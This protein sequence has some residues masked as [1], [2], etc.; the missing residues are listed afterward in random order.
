[1]KSMQWDDVRHFLALSRE[2]S[3]SATARVLRVDHST[4][5]RRVTSLETALQTKLFDRMARGWLLTEKG[6]ELARQ[7]SLLEEE[8][9]A[10]WRA[11][12]CHAALSGRV[13]IS[14]PP[15]LLNEFLVPRLSGFTQKHPAIELELIGETRGADLNRSEADIALRMCMPTNAQLV[16]RRLCQVSYMLYGLEKWRQAPEQEQVFIGFDRASLDWRKTWLELHVGPRRYAL[17]TNS[18]RAMCH[19]ALSGLGIALLPCFLARANERLGPV[20]GLAEPLTCPVYLVM[21]SDVRRAPRIR[22]TADFLIALFQAEEGY[23]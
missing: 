14:A 18:M 1:M 12:S 11:A 15:L 5:A 21:H 7:A 8:M 2:G 23:F 6:Q 3:L 17:R 16:A 9:Q 4:V 19:A 20:P 10:L 22:A 13:R